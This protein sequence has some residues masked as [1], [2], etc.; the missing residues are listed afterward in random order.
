MITP[1]AVQRARGS[2]SNRTGRT[3]STPEIV[4]CARSLRP[5]PPS[6]QPHLLSTIVRLDHISVSGLGCLASPGDGYC[7]RVISKLYIQG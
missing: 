4:W 6:P 1:N 3:S 5:Q 7:K 2:A